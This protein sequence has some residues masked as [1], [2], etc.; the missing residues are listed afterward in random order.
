MNPTLKKI[1]KFL[2]I[3]GLL[4]LFLYLALRSVNFDDLVTE[5]KKTNYLLAIAGGLVGVFIGSYFRALRWRYFLNPIKENISMKNLFP[6]IMIGYM[7]NSVIPRGGEFTR[8]IILAR[9]EDISKAASFGTILVERIFDVLSV[10]AAFG[11][12]LFAFKD[13]LGAA[14]PEYNIEKIAVV[15]SLITLAIIIFLIIVIFNIEKSELVIEKI[16]GKFFPEKIQ[17][18]IKK[19]FSSTMSGFLFIKYPKQY[20]PI[21][22]YTVLIWIMYLLSAYITFFAC[23]INNL[24]LVDANLVLTMIT[25][26]MFLPLPGNSAGAFHYIC[27]GTLVNIFGIDR[28]VAFGYATVNHLTGF[29]LQILIGAYYFFKENYKVKDFKK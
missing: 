15:A 20:L 1:L 21:F 5:L 18:K 4:A 27:S 22:I 10:L 17:A 13:K 3:T 28:E 25:F 14:F 11:I 19:F 6:P 7:L 12:S 29:I 24:N 23:G 9:N 16:T 8:P 2:L 26:A